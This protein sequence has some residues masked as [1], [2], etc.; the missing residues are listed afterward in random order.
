MDLLNEWLDQRWHFTKML[1]E[2]QDLSQNVPTELAI[3]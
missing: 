3:K 2:L 1:T